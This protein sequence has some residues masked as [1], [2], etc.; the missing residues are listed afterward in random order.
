MPT[1]TTVALDTLIEPKASK[2]AATGRTKP[3]PK[4]ERRNSVGITGVD[5]KSNLRSTTMTVDRK[6]HWTQ[7]SPALYATPEPTPVPDSPLSF[8]TSPYIVDHKRRGPRL[9]K[10]FSQDDAVLHQSVANEPAVKIKKSVEAEDIDSSKVF[11]FVD[12]VAG[13]VKGKHVKFQPNE[14]LGKAEDVGS[15]QAF[16]ITDTVSGDVKDTHLKL[17]HKA[18]KY[19]VSRKS[20]TFERDGEIDDF[21]DPHD[22]M[23]VISNSA[24]ESSH[25]VE[26]S[27]HSNTPFAEFFDAWEGNLVS[28]YTRILM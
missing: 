11:E 26:R 18:D 13:D 12:A 9:S 5:R 25:A 22:S 15:S 10:T 14:N 28:L 23:S 3:E 27:L 24:G 19:D 21:F 2:L 16:G 6:H 7:I 17:L 4:L 1:F 20:D 8:P